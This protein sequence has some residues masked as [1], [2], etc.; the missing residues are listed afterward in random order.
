MAKRHHHAL[1]KLQKGTLGKFGY[2]GVRYKKA[3]T[4]HRALRK[5]VKRLGFMKVFKKLNAVALVNRHNNPAL[6]KIFKADRNWVRKLRVW[7][8]SGDF[9]YSPY[10]VDSKLM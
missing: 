8:G 7:G 10:S 3:S 4:R 1:F 5:A 6:A 2:H 9:K